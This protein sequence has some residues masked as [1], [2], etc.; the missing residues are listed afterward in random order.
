MLV[1]RENCINAHRNHRIYVQILL[2]QIQFLIIWKDGK[3][4]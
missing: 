1:G 2:I 3:L 4:R